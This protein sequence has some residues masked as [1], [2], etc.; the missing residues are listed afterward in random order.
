MAFD[1]D[2]FAATSERITW[3]DLDLDHFKANPLSADS[4]RTLRYMADVEYHTVCYTRDLLTTPSHK[5]GDVSTFMTMWNREEFWHGEAL[6]AILE[7]HGIKV[8]YDQLRANRLKLGWRDKLDP[9]KQGLLGK[10]VGSD[11]VA[12]HMS[13]GAANEYSAVS[14]YKRMAALEKDPV[15]AE[16]L[17]RI[18]KQESRHVAFYVSQARERLLKSKKAQKLTRFLL[19]KVWAPVGSSIMDIDDVRFVFGQLM[20]G[21]EGR[22]AAEKLDH[23]ISNLPGMTG[24][25]IFQKALDGLGV[26]NGPTAGGPGGVAAA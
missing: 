12:V 2:K 24:L 23:N 25:R 6:A 4:L 21:E 3:D 5:E 19:Q 1:I 16:L 18:A 9:V 22:K 17:I 14:A 26:V 15:L 13:W 11:F 7:V 8:D 20:S 10:F